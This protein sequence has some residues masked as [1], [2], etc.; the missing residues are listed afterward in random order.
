MK[1]IKKQDIFQIEDWSMDYPGTSYQYTVGCYPTATRSDG[2]LLWQ[3]VG[4]KMRIGL[5][6]GTLA[7]AEEC[8]DSLTSGDK[9]IKDYSRN[10]WDPRTLAYID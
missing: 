10:V 1:I 2:S 6:F 4:Q 5:S 8:Y 3:T 9:R 7:E